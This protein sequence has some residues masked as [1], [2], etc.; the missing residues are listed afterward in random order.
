MFSDNLNSASYESVSDV[1]VYLAL[2]SMS[3]STFVRM[4]KERIIIAETRH[5]Q[6][7]PFLEYAAE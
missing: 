2:R 6:M 1:L 4:W 7:L 5:V 3:V